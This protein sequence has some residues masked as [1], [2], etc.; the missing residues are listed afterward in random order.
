MWVVSV[1]KTYK[2]RG[3][4]IK[5]RPNTK[6][7]WRIMYY[8]KNYDDQWQLNSRFV[9]RFEAF[10]YRFRKFYRRK[11]FCFECGRIFVGLVKK[12]QHTLE[13]PYCED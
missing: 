2:H 8:E 12:R 1:S 10:F 4:Y 7:H 6:K 5:H 3:K 9:N 11:F 13:C